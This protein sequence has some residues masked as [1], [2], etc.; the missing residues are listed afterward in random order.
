MDEFEAITAGLTADA[1]T[2]LD[3]PARVTSPD[4]PDALA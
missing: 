2:P 3:T 4:A 1:L